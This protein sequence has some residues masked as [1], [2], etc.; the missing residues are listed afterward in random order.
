MKGN[1]YGNGE[2]KGNDLSETCHMNKDLYETYINTNFVEIH[3]Y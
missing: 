2:K 3:S 1:L